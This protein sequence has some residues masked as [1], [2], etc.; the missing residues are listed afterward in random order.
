MADKQKIIQ[1]DFYDGYYV[2]DYNT[3]A[4]AAIDNGMG[5][6]IKSTKI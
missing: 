2:G 5:H 4:E 3:I 6:F 1:L